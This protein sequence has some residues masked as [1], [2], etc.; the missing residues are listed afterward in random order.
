MIYRTYEEKLSRLDRLELFLGPIISRYE[1][2]LRG[3]EE[4]MTLRDRQSPW[5]RDE[6]SDWYR[7]DRGTTLE[8]M[9][10]RLVAFWSCI[11][12]LFLLSLKLPVS[13]R[14]FLWD[15]FLP[16][17]DDLRF[18][19]GPFV[20]SF[21]GMTSRLSVKSRRKQVKLPPGHTLLRVLDFFFSPKT[22]ALTFK[23]LLGD[24][25]LEYFEALKEKRNLKARWISVRYYWAFA[26][27]CG[28]SK[29]PKALENLTRIARK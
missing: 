3:S 22:V 1:Q 17:M 24:W 6:M 25:H 29:I 27:A 16:T 15:D 11:C 9:R 28:L 4:I 19:V 5:Y 21:K 10:K 2:K 14:N 13:I 18:Y 7:D 26:K 12:L 23:P 20:R 8:I